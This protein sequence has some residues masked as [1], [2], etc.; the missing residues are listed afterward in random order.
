MKIDVHVLFCTPIY[1]DDGKIMGCQ[2]TIDSD[3]LINSKSDLKDAIYDAVASE[4]YDA[5]KCYFDYDELYIDNLD[6][7]L[8]KL[9]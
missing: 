3:K 5:F 1:T 4:L 9:S 2:V 6:E 7:I 8:S